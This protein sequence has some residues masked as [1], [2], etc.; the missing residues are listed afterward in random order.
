FVMGYRPTPLPNGQFRHEYAVFNVNSDRAGGSFSVALPSG[1]SA[2]NVTFKDVK[3]HSGEPI[4]DTDWTNAA[5]AGSSVTWTCTSVPGTT[6]QN[7]AANPLRWGTLFNFGFQSA[8]SW[9]PNVTLGLWKAGT[10]ASMS[11][12]FCPS[13]GLPSTPTWGTFAQQTVSYDFLDA[14][15]GTN[16]PVGDDASVTAPLPFTFY[17]YDQPLTQI[18]ISTNGYLTMPGQPGDV[19][20]NATIPSGVAPNGLIAG[21]WDDLEIAGA[22]GSASG[23]CRYKTFGVAPTRRFV[24]E[25]FNAQRQGQNNNFSFEIILDE[26]TNAI[27]LTQISTATGATGGSATR[28]VER[29]DGA[30]GVQ[31]TYNTTTVG[32]TSSVRLNYTPGTI[33]QSALLTLTGNGSIASPLVWR[34]VSEPSKPIT[35]FA[36]IVP[37][38]IYV[39][40]FGQ[41][42]LSL[43]ATMLAIFDGTGGFAPADPTAVTDGCNLWTKS[44]ALQ[45][46]PLPL[47]LGLYFQGV[48]WSASAPNG[49]AH[50]TTLATL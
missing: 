9:L 3:F 8:A 35:L 19:Y 11:A 15:T 45:P 27:T 39:P 22:G 12:T 23:W 7:N 31:V 48:V 18:E 1:V 43:G 42:E 49:T 47:P 41:I 44:L 13:T 40:Y 36:D 33:P 50:L 14:T 10:P 37:G 4:V 5:V 46:G 28:G 2:S 6:A 16:G 17:F 32:G 26:G 24:V 34:I 20:D 30:A 25:W 21:Y 29:P 38:P